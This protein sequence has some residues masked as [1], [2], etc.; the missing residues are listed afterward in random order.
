M[1]IF[2]AGERVLKASKEYHLSMQELDDAMYFL[3]KDH[4]KER[5]PTFTEF[6]ENPLYLPGI[7]DILYPIWKDTFK[8]IYPSVFF[9]PYYLILLYACTSA[10]KSLVLTIIAAYELCK[11]L[12]LKNPLKTYHLGTSDIMY[13]DFHMPTK[14]LGEQTNWAKF[15]NLLNLSPFFLKEVNIPS[16]S[17]NFG[18][19]TKNIALELITSAE[20][21][22]SKAVYF[23][24]MD[25][26]N[27]KKH[28]QVQNDSIYK[29]LDRRMEGRFMDTSGFVPYKFVIASSPKDSSDE[30]S[31][32]TEELDDLTE[33]GNK[34]AYKTGSIPQWLTRGCNLN[35]C[36]RKF[37]VYVG[38][39]YNEPF[40]IKEGE[41]IPEDVDFEK[42]HYVPIEYLRSFEQDIIGAI[43]DI[44]GISTNKSGRLY[45]SAKHLEA[46]LCQNNLFTS[47]VIKIPFN[48]GLKEG[49]EL[50]MSYFRI[51]S[52]K[53]P[54]Y[55]RAIH[56]DV[57][58]S[59]DRLGLSGCFVIPA[60]H[61]KGG[62]KGIFKDNMFTSDFTV[63][64]ESYN[65]EEIPLDVVVGF[66]D[67]INRIG[68]PV[69]LV[70]YDG[71]QS[72]AISQPLTRLKIENKLQ[73]LD[74][75]KDPYLIH[76]RAVISGRYIGAKNNICLKEYLKLENLPTKI[77]HP[78]NGSKDLSDATTGAF[79]GAFMN[80]DILLKNRRL[81][82]V[83]QRSQSSN[84][85][86]R[87]AKSGFG[88]LRS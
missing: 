29:Y 65:N 62:G 36:G 18:L 16:T 70:T 6:L 3:L 4:Y 27:E 13:F 63:G 15:I 77:D 57:A 5:P 2:E 66:I 85:M 26:Y 23:V 17:S 73:S 50:L 68:Y 79:F 69:G 46:S 58:L 22:V 51:N 53:F 11:V 54:E 67:K 43:Q 20:D 25:E 83:L 37:A 71:Y 52:V 40:L 10:G 84:L 7:N 47:E 41:S 12:C 82:K 44:L 48:I 31:Q 76:K 38:D 9:N 61:I 80:E 28:A 75:T 8:K 60:N 39:E 30:L 34:K 24:G 42:V 64:L 78:M 74:K 45:S 33:V 55:A 21:T 87:L 88:R 19:L 59:G 32:L 35:Y 72:A 56:V 1:D 81:I 14:T 86:E 49:V